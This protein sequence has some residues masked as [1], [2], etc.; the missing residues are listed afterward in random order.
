MK[1]QPRYLADFESGDNV[2]V[3]DRDKDFRFE[4]MKTQEFISLNW[5]KQ[6]GSLGIEA[7]HV[8]TSQ[9][10]AAQ[11]LTEKEILDFVS[12]C[13]MKKVEFRLLPESAAMTYRSNYNLEKSGW[14][15]IIAY[16]NELKNRPNLWNSCLRSKNLT[17]YDRQKDIRTYEE[18]T[19]QL[20]GFYY[21]QQLKDDSR[22]LSASN[23]NKK[24]KTCIPGKIAH[25]KDCIEFVADRLSKHS[26]SDSG[27]TNGIAKFRFKDGRTVELSLLEVLSIEKSKKGRKWNNPGKEAAYVACMMLFIDLNGN[28]YINRR[29]NQ[30]MSWKDI[31]QYG[32]VSTAFH[33]KPGFLR[34]KFYHHGIKPIVKK[35]ECEVFG[36]KEIDDPDYGKRIVSN[37]DNT[38]LEHIQFRN[39]LRNT[40][41][42]AF[43]QTAKG[44]REYLKIR[45]NKSTL[46]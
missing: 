40:C 36:K 10:S 9:W 23:I 4:P 21:R 17:F 41:R 11:R 13:E 26:S 15:D 45:K 1:Y 30:S 33:Q 20:A 5:M 6:T 34:P 7:A 8:R 28:E 35:Y 3:Y 27:I 37:R 16:H 12:L 32:M 31:K 29:T 18:Y 24:Y 22:K 43:E 42:I 39:W 2:F 44:M 46:F 38:N 19:R 14:N 25:E